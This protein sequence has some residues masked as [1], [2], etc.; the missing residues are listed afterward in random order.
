MRHV[1]KSNSFKI[2]IGL[3][4]RVMHLLKCESPDDILEKKKYACSFEVSMEVVVQTV[5][6]R[7]VTCCLRVQGRN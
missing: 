7:V 5:V 1:K 6:L 3:D 2:R 4:F